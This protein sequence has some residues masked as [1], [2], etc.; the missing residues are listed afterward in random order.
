MKRNRLL[1]RLGLPMDKK[2][3]II[4]ADDIGIA[5]PQNQ[6][7]LKALEKGPVNSG[8]IMANGA[9]FD[10]IA[11]YVGSNTYIDFGIHLTLTS[12]WAN[13]KQKPVLPADA[14]PSLIDCNGSFRG[15]EFFHSYDLLEVEKEVCA[16]VDKALGAGIQLTHIDCHMNCM[17]KGHGF[18]D[19]YLGLGSKYKLPLLLYKPYFYN[20]KLEPGTFDIND[21]IF[22]DNICIAAPETL[23]NELASF[24]AQTLNNL[25]PG[26]NILLV[27]PAFNNP[28]MKSI[29][30]N[31]IPYGAEWRQEDFNYFTSGTCEELIAE[32]Q[33]QLITWKEIKE[34]LNY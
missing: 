24:Y 2:L 20:F 27:H 23:V 32:N 16:Q 10:E 18:M 15:E 4:H 5:S 33:I 21:A 7:S 14:V 30:G 8:S 6:A 9:G 11:S 13:F 34:T 17:Y 25:V 3:L 12:E 31:V 22:A 1:K 19:I 28:E 29:T 26:L